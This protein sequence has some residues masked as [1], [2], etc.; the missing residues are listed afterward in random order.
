MP[1]DEVQVLALNAGKAA[2][3]DPVRQTWV[4]QELGPFDYIQPAKKFKYR[5]SC[6]LVDLGNPTNSMEIQNLPSVMSFDPGIKIVSMSSPGRNN[7]FQHYT[8]AEDTLDFELSY[9]AQ[10]ENRQDVIK[11]CKWV[12]AM[13]KNDAYTG[14]PK[15]IGIFWTSPDESAEDGGGGLGAFL[16]EATWLIKAAPYEVS[17]FHGARRL[18]PTLATQK[19][20]LVRVSKH[21]RTREEIRSHNK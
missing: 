15:L 16:E 12:E 9:Y 6:Y 18:M 21:N 7:P 10:E 2:Q 3:W 13:A 4:G 8:G 19:I 17:L 20:S 11:K 1:L 14:K 5:R